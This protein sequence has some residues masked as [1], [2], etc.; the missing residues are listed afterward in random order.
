MFVF[1]LAFASFLSYIPFGLK[2][3]TSTTIDDFLSLARVKTPSAKGVEARVRLAFLIL[4]G[5]S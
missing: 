1:F 4:V 2:S 5:G 3:E